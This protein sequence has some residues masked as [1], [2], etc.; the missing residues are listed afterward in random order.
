VVVRQQL[1]A[2]ISGSGINAVLVAPQFAVDARDS[3]A[4]NFWNSGGT[5]RFLDEAAHQLA[6]ML[7]DSQSERLFSR[8]PVVIV[9][10]SGGYVPAAATLA[11]GKL[12]ERVKGVV[13]L[14]GLYGEFD[15]FARWIEQTR[16]GFFLS[17]YATSTRKGNA[18]LMDILEK[19]GVAYTTELAPTLAPRSVTFVRAVDSHRDYVTRAWARHPVSDLLSRIA[20]AAPRLDPTRSAALS[21]SLAN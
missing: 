16:S 13:L 12:G 21:A 17:A 3:S 2:Q 5:K 20:W 9:G 19:R 7:D 15:R 4:G 14:D 11:N 6:R 18:A 8:M 1:P 10:Y